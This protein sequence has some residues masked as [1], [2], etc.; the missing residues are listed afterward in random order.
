M[1]YSKMTSSELVALMNA[2]S[3]IDIAIADNCLPDGFADYAAEY[4]SADASE[5]ASI[6]E[7]ITRLI[8]FKGYAECIGNEG[9]ADA[10]MKVADDMKGM[11]ARELKSVASGGLSK[12]AEK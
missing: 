7:G 6:C 9:M 5:R 2:F 12:L 4:I 3:H 8:A 10:L 1:D 11:S